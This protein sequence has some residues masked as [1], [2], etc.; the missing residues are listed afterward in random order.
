MVI[1]SFVQSEIGPLAPLLVAVAAFG[2]F[3][4][5]K[6]FSP[7]AYL[8]T[9]GGN[10]GAGTLFDQLINGH[11]YYTQSEWSNGD[12]GCEL[13]PPSGRIAPRFTMPRG[14]N[15]AGASLSFNP[16][17]S[18]S[19]NALSSATWNFGDG[20]QTAFFSGK[21][22]LT[23]AKHRYRKARRYTVTLTL[24]DNRGNLQTTTRGVTVHAH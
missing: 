24:V 8:P 1:E 4:P 6:G 3:D 18:T 10:A 22:A 5:A 16:A 9:L 14:S 19:T 7:Y 21:A 15:K 20:S 23:P 17:K 12:N 2:P 13:R 11:P